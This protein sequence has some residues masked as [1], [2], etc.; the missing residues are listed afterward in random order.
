MELDSLVAV[1]FGARKGLRVDV[2]QSDELV[3]LQV[4]NQNTDL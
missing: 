3:P 2:S 4:P 1:F